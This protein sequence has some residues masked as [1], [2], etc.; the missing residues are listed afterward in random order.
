MPISIR[1]TLHIMYMSYTYV[2]PNFPYLKLCFISNCGWD[3][4]SISTE[5]DGAKIR[6]FTQKQCSEQVLH[7]E[8][9]TIILTLYILRSDE[10]SCDVTSTDYVGVK[11]QNTH[12]C[13]LR[14]NV[15]NIFIFTECFCNFLLQISRHCVH[16]MNSHYCV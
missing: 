8:L 9:L 16:R 2:M 6:T 11:S 1:I 4:I 3:L 14:M 13:D 15:V 10:V 7:E 5:E 12:P